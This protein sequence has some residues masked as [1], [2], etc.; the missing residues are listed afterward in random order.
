MPLERAKASVCR[1]PAEFAGL[2]AEPPLDDGG[3]TFRGTADVRVG[4]P[5]DVRA[6]RKA[7]A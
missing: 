6:H 7:E 4:E 2:P 5:V 3:A 1:R